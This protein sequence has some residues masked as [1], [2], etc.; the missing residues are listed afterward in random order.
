MF[1]A[2]YHIHSSASIDAVDSMTDM[3]RAAAAR[4]IESLCFTDHVDLED[5]PTGIY[6]PDYWSRWPEVLR[7]YDE[8]R[9]ALPQA[10]IRLGMELGAAHH[11][12]EEAAKCAAHGELDFIIGSIHNLRNTKDFY[13]LEYTSREQCLALAR[14]YMAE[15]I[16]L[17][18]ADYFDVVA[19]VG[20]TRRYMFKAGFDL[21]VDTELFGDELRE[22][23]KILIERGRGIEVNC[24]DFRRPG[25]AGPVPSLDVLRLYREMGGEIITTGSD[26]HRVEDAGG[27]IADGVEA[28]LA[29]GFKYITLFEKRKP[30]FR[31]L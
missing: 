31:R 22:V 29:A 28:L 9:R 12:Q 10:D 2:D 6:N 27:N 11:V 19:H 16:E 3:A 21:R 15:H 5:D 13:F 7:Q 26:A 30:V 24:S 8:A 4:G 18:R 17:A 1:L 25:I 20:Y 23:F 14:K